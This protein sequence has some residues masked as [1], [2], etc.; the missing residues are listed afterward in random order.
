MVVFV[1]FDC[2]VVVVVVVEVDVF[3]MKVVGEE[4]FDVDVSAV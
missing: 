1:V 3:G 2:D 4:F